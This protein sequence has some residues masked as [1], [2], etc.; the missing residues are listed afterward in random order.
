[1]PVSLTSTRTNPSSRRA[2]TVMLPSASVYLWALEMRFVRICVTRS[3]IGPYGRQRVAKV[4]PEPLPLG[5]DQRAQRAGDLRDQ[6][7]EVQARAVEIEP[8]GLHAREI[9]EIVDQPQQ[10]LR[11]L[12]DNG[13]ALP[14]RSG[15][16]LVL[17]QQ[18]GVPLDRGEGSPQLVRNNRDELGL[19][20]VRLLNGQVLLLELVVFPAQFL[21][22]K[23]PFVRPVQR[24]GHLVE[25]AGELAQ[26]PLPMGKPGAHTQLPGGDSLR[27]SDKGLDLAHE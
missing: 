14:V 21:L 20:P 22:Q 2:P 13:Q 17:E 4:E 5:F 19:Q 9:K 24:L 15:D 6:T 23:P 1:M 26:L 3:G 25:G 10:P 16:L 7:G 12:L 8:A 18:L 11:V 27:R